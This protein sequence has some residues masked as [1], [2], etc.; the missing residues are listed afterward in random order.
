MKTVTS[1]LFVLS[2]LVFLMTVENM[3]AQ[4]TPVQPAPGTY[5]QQPAYSLLEGTWYGTHGNEEL[6]IVFK[7]YKKRSMGKIFLD[8]LYGWYEYKI[9]GQVNSSTLDFLYD[10][11]YV[12]IGAFDFKELAVNEKIRMTVTDPNRISGDGAG[13]IRMLDN[14]D[15]LF[16]IES[17]ESNDHPVL[18][19][20]GKQIRERRTQ[21]SQLIENMRTWTMSKID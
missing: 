19:I 10:S 18:S 7:G 9:D 21:K 4:Q 17:R 15:I 6:T 13:Y 20:D 11:N 2:A 3:T 12:T 1:K 16:S 8:I 5:V 14:G